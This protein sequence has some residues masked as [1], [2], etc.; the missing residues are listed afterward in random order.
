METSKLKSKDSSIKVDKAAAES[1][2]ITEAGEMKTNR[3][4]KRSSGA[5]EKNLEP[6]SNALISETGPKKSIGSVT[7]TKKTKKEGQKSK[8]S[9]LHDLKS[10]GGE[11]NF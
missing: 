2:K 6:E 5:T 10:E 8:S 11:V 4:S 3:V 9:K 1:T 7:Q